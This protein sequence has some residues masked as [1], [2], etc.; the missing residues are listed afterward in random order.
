MQ[1]MLDKNDK[2]GRPVKT[3]QI[4]AQPAKVLSRDQR[5]FYFKNGYLVLNEFIGQDWLDRIW[6]VTNRFINESRNYTQSD[7][8]FDLEPNHTAEQPRLRRLSYP[9]AHHEIY[10]EFAS[11]GPI[12]DVAEDLLG[13]DVVFHHSKLNFKWS[14]GGEEVKWHQ[15]YP[16]YPHTAYSV[17]ALSLIH[18]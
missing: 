17:L 1:Q 14:G 18:I 15:D 11:Q 6:Q 10:W 3:E 7:A 2:R 4:L 13:P 5:E 16:Y 8:K 9:T 12:V